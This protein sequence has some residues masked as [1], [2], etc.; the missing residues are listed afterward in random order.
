MS[1][2]E[3]FLLAGGFFSV[4][5]FCSLASVILDQGSGRI[6]FTLAVLAGGSF[7]L[8]MVYAEAGLDFNDIPPAINKFISIYLK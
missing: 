8:A 3:I 4:L 6:F 1:T 7:Y 5:G 2:Y